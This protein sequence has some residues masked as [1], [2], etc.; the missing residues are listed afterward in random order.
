MAATSMAS[1]VDGIDADADLREAGNGDSTQVFISV[2]SGWLKMILVWQL[3][4]KDRPGL[5]L[6]QGSKQL[7]ENS[8]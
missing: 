5:A 6:T 4:D 8:N 3:S 1:D 2:V 7:R